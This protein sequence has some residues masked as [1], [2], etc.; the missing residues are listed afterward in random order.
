MDNNELKERFIDE[1]TGIEYIRK[2]DY[3]FPNLV[4]SASVKANELSKY[5]KLRL[6]YLLE[7]K[8][9]DYT[10]LW[11]ENK[12]RSH[13]L[14][15]DKTANKRF[16][17]LMKQFTALQ[18]MRNTKKQFFK[19][20]G[21]QCFHGVQSFVK[22]EVTQEQAHEIGIKLAEELWGNKFQVIVST[23]LNTDN[24]HN[25]FVLNYVS[26]LDGKRFCNTK[27]DYATMRKA[28]DK[29]CEEYGLSVLKQEEKYNKYTTS[30][31]YK[32]LMKDSIDYA[33]ANAKD[34]NEF[35][36]ILQD[37]DYIVTDKNNTLSIR[38]ELCKRNT[39]I[40]RQFGNSYSKESIYKRILET[41]P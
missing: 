37:L 31:L 24:L 3:Y 34:Y 25:H 19:T 39:R 29:L 21:I 2:G 23:H 7:H 14:E 9:V 22:G 17:L 6:K 36:K 4:D 10:I 40:E 38:Q 30:S 11:V 35:I 8:K 13:L 27:K 5:G 1:K 12:L 41:Q 20:T 15:I 33:I 16:N 26:F 18:E 32:E 28:S